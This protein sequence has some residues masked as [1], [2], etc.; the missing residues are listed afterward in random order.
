[1]LPVIR[2]DII[3]DAQMSPPVPTTDTVDTRLPLL[4]VV[5]TAIARSGMRYP[6]IQLL[7]SETWQLLS[8]N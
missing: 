7:T 3:N 8:L 2:R 1:M 6:L 5:T 4:I